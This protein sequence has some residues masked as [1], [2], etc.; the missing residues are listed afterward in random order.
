MVQA[1]MATYF[2]VKLWWLT[3][4]VLTFH[5]VLIEKVSGI[6][7][8]GI[9]V[10]IHHGVVRGRA[11][12]PSGLRALGIFGNGHSWQYHDRP[13][14]AQWKQ[15]LLVSMVINCWFD[16]SPRNVGPRMNVNNCGNH[17]CQWLIELQTNECIRL[18]GKLYW[19]VSMLFGER[20]LWTLEDISALLARALS[21]MAACS[22]I[23]VP[24]HWAV[25]VLD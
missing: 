5:S 14:K 22:P 3:D 7:T 12:H 20:T 15:C 19:F 24:L 1:K 9:I 11:I 6:E 25:H 21:T 18:I 23:H 4:Q 2:S 10:F 16:E 13:F 8:L 17:F